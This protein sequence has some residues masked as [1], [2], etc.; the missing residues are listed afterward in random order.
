MGKEKKYDDVEQEF[1]EYEKEGDAI[2][3]IYISN[4]SEVGENKSMVYFLEQPN[5]KIISIWGSTKLDSL[6]K[7]VKFQD[8]IRIEFLG[9]KK[10]EGKRDYKDFKIQKAETQAQIQS[11]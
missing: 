9:M 8:D 10:S 7:L 5:S 2:V 4:Q 1:W 3:G 6:M 11:A